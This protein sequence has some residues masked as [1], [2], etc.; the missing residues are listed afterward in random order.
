MRQTDRL[1]LCVDLN[2][3]AVKRWP[4]IDVFDSEHNWL[5]ILAVFQDSHMNWLIQFQEHSG[6]ELDLFVVTDELE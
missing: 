1:D 4:P 5:L 6:V 2:L 3:V